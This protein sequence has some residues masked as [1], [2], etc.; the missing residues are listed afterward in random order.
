MEIQEQ[1][2]LQEAQVIIEARSKA[3]KEIVAKK[4]EKAS[5]I[6]NKE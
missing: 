1:A 4:R 5:K 6:E 3:R 2:A